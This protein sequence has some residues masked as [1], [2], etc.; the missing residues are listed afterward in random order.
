MRRTRRRGGFTLVEI[1]TVMAVIVVLIGLSIPAISMIRTKSSINETTALFQ[2]LTLAL[3]TYNNDFGDYPPSSPKRLGLRGN[4]QNDGAEL[5][6][7]CLTTQAR[8]GNYFSFEDKQLGNVDSDRLP[9]DADPTR[10]SYKTR[11]LFELLDSWGNPIGYLHNADYAVGGS[12]TL[13]TG[14]AAF[15]AARSEKTGQELGLTTYQLW[16]A[17]P[18]GLA[19]T[20]DDIVVA[21]Q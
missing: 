15:T 1:L 7:R 19:G 12:V 21:G 16:S 9:S 11:D 10:S 6:V 8:S 4:G 2:R 5:L 13:P 14:L 18:D 3:S 17:G 20:P